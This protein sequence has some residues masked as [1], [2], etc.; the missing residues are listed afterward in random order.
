MRDQIICQSFLA[1]F[2]DATKTVVVIDRAG[3]TASVAGGALSGY[4]STE[5]NYFAEVASLFGKSPQVLRKRRQPSNFS[6]GHQ[7]RRRI[8]SRKLM[9][10]NG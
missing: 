8:N 7:K 4:S 2:T 9:F 10:T 6:T 5:R 1:Y 3:D